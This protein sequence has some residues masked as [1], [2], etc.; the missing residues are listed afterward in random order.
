LFSDWGAI[1]SRRELSEIIY[2]DL[3][4]SG[5]PLYSIPETIKTQQ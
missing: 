4:F 5:N 2:L 1:S 3:G